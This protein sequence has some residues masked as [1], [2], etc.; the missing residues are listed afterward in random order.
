MASDY[1]ND[2][3]MPEVTGLLMAAALRLADVLGITEGRWALPFAPI[4]SPG[5]TFAPPSASAFLILARRPGLPAVSSV[6]QYY[7][8]RLG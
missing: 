2:P 6:V 4:R 1:V 3:L 8:A 7:P 5:L